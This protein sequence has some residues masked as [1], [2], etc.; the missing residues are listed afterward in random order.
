MIDT[1]EAKKIYQ[2]GDRVLIDQQ[3]WVI[4]DDLNDNVL[5]YRDSVDGRSRTMK[6]PKRDLPDKSEFP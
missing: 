4:A 5:L 6:Y 1:T 3:E 2:I